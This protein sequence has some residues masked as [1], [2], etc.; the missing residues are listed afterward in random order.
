MSQARLLIEQAG[1]LTNVQD[2]GRPSFA[3]YGVPPSGPVDRLAFTAALAALR[4]SPG[5]TAIELSLGGITL[6]CVTG[7]VAFALTGGDF[8]ADRDGVSLGGWTVGRLSAGMRLRV[9]EGTRGNWAYLA[10]AGTIAAPAW[11]GSRSTLMLAGLGGGR[12]EA[13]AEVVI[14]G[15]T[16]TPIQGPITPPPDAT[17]I[18][19]AR[20]V[21]G[22]QERFFAADTIAHLTGKPFRASSAFDRM[23][24][25]LDG[26]PLVPL[27]LD[28]PSEPAVRGAL[29]VNGAG[30]LTLLSADHQTTGG[31]PKIGVV[32]DADCDRVAQLRAGSPCRFVAID[33]DDARTVA[34]TQRTAHA[35]WLAGLS[36][37]PLP[38]A[39]LMSANLIGGMVD[40]LDRG[41]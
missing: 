4:N 19:E 41:D 25:V 36:A 14:E 37:R 39:L 28:M 27:G 40:A 17:P 35:A 2:A 18:S 7:E 15:A 31:Y 9:R 3:R 29:Q 10:F 26:P 6:H 21:L 22:P 38:E 30:A 1:P 8:T 20:V 13:G 23:G 16:I 33:A 32:I 5:G 12:I 34:W 24:L 11:L